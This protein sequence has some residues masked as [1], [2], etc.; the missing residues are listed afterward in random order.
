[1]SQTKTQNHEAIE[2]G[3]RQATTNREYVDRFD[4]L[5]GT[6]IGK[7]FWIAASLRI[8]SYNVCYTKLLRFIGLV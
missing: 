4:Q 5:N 6:Q 3:M 8:T 7:L 2:A 1:M